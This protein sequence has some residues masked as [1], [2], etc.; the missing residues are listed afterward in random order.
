MDPL[1][2]NWLMSP[3]RMWNVSL[4]FAFQLYIFVYYTHLKVSC[5]MY[6]Y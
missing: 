3:T 2:T 6:N 5:E 4:L 1:V